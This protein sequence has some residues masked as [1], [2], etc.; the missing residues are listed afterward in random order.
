MPDFSHTSRRKAERW[1]RRHVGSHMARIYFSNGSF[2]VWLS[3]Q[4]GYGLFVG[5]VQGKE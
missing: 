2:T 4:K 5:I 3:N 1:A